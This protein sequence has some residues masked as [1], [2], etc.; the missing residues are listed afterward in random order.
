M[1][2][3]IRECLSCHSICLETVSRSLEE[4]GQHAEPKPITVL[5]DCAAICQTSADFMLRGSDLYALTCAT[6]A[7]ICEACARE[8]ERFNHAFLQRCAEACRRC[9]DSCRQMAGTHR[10]G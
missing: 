6:C 10:A 9:A 5:L 7:E 8:C 3:C 1:E 4:G 2:S